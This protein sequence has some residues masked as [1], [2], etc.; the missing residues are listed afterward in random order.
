MIYKYE[1]NSIV[2]LSDESRPLIVVEAYE[3]HL[4]FRGVN[5]RI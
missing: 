1:V 4:G 3:S 2:S 5:P